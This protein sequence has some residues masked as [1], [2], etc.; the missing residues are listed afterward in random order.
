MTEQ[1]ATSATRHPPRRALPPTTSRRS[2]PSSRPPTTTLTGARA[3][4]RPHPRQAGRRPARPRRRPAHAPPAASRTPRGVDTRNYGGLEGIARAA[5][6][7]RRAAVGRARAGRRRRQ[8]QPGDDA[9]RARRP[10]GCTAAVDSERPW[11]QEEKVTFICPVPGYDRHFTLL[12]LVRHRDGHRC[13]CTTTAPTPRRSPRWSPTTRASRA[14]GSCRPTPTRPARSSP[15]RSPPGWPRCRPRR[16]TSRSSGTT[17]TR[18]TTSPRTRPRAP[19][20]SASPRP[21]GTRTARSCSPR[22]PRS[23]SPAPASRSSPARSRP[24]RWYLGHLGKGAIGPDKVNQLRHAQF[25]G[26]AAGRARPHGQ[27]P[28]DHRAEVRRGGAHPHRAP[29]RPGRRHLD[30]ADR[31][32]LRQPR[33]ARRHRLPRGRA[34]QGGRRSR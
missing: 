4:A 31:R 6:D 25:F 23:P 17:P 11:G 7:V 10:A 18:S 8:L 26:S 12:Q 13:R 33:R 32:L 27:A 28:R 24:C 19:T 9:R 20:S 15:R 14:C 22:P 1:T 30:H 2:P 3:Q 5:R 21:P 29:R 16:P 34:G